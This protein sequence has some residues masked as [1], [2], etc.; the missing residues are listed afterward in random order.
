MVAK[1]FIYKYTAVINKE[2]SIVF[3]VIILLYYRLMKNLILYI[4]GM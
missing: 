4:R 1:H 3:N 2:I